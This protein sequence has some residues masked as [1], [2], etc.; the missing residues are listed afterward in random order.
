MALNHARV[1]HALQKAVNAARDEFI[2]A[3]LAAFGTSP[4]TL[5]LLESRNAAS[6]PGDVALA[7]KIYI[8]A[9]RQGCDLE[10]ALAEIRALPEI[11][12]KKIRFILAHDFERALAFD[13]KTTDSAA[14]AFADL[15][16]NYEFFL[17]LTG[18][19]EKAETWSD[20]PADLRACE[21]MGQLY[22]GI[23]RKNADAR[24]NVHLLNV[25]L[26]RLLFCFFAE[27]T[28]IFPEERQMTH[29]LA[30]HTQTDGSDVARFFDDLFAVLDLPPDARE[31]AKYPPWI[32]A[33]PYV[34]GSLF[35]EKCPIPVFDYRMR[36]LLLQCGNMKW[37]EISPAIF[38]SMFQ[39]VM[40]PKKR[41]GLGAHYTSEKNILKLIRPLFLDDLEVAFEKIL[42]RK[43]G[44]AAALKDY[45]RNLASLGFL[46]P[47]CGC[48]NFLII[49]FR[50]IRE[51]ELR[52]LLALAQC[53]GA[54]NSTQ[55]GLEM[56]W[57]DVG[58]LSAISIDQ[59]H[60]IE[61]EEFPAQIARVSLWL[62][63]HVMNM[64][65]GRAFGRVVSS[66]PLKTS[67]RIV[68]GD[69]LDLEWREVAEPARTSYILG[70]P[71]FGGSSGLD[72][73]RKGQMRAI[74]GNR[75]GKLDYVAAWYEKAAAFMRHNP[76]IQAAFVST[77][78]ICQGE[79]VAPLWQELF[80]RGIRI[81][82]AHQTFQWSNEARDNAA[83]YCVIIGFSYCEKERKILFAYDNPRS[84]AAWHYCRHINPYLAPA[85]LVIVT[86]AKKALSAPIPMVYGNKPTDGGNLI[87]EARDID[88]FLRK[89]PQGT[90]FVK[91][92]IGSE[93]FLH[94]KPRYCL[95]LV[96]A[97][98]E[99]LELPEIAKRIE[100]CRQMRLA[101]VDAGCRRLAERAHLFRDL[102]NPPSSLAIPG[103]S[104]ERREYIPIGF[105]DDST[106]AS[107]LVHI[108]PNAGLYEFGIV[109]SAMHMA[110][111][112]IVCGRLKSD[113]RYSRDLCYN[114]FPWPRVGE[115]Q[116]ERVCG[117]A[118]HVLE[119]REKYPQFTLAQLYD[120]EKMPADLR[121]AHAALD[122][123]V[124]ALY[125]KKPFADDADR[126]RLL[127]AL[128]KKLI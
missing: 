18:L 91:K 36:Y 87:I 89:E 123:A 95:W 90:P 81:N 92:L 83:V 121:A 59:F 19:Y 62:M 15:P 24:D 79:Q 44:R 65:L 104:S 110:W 61:I 78:S 1:V 28:G 75:G 34:N 100:G 23:L 32:A 55:A 3:F 74:L 96:D 2:P 53:A 128:Y 54:E 72:K 26:T 58:R 13:G 10:A 9:A 98:P 107:N 67:A 60:G 46:D 68:G 93:E 39:A 20:H 40:D 99:I 70:N 94:K 11:S 117:L 71:P 102:C 6:R 7:G 80:D 8:H 76:Q 17:P 35:A 112:R 105:I 63:E 33:F 101:S 73:K 119:L 113:Y 56:F 124:D 111:M 38:G 82:F 37:S 84:E 43:S 116:R 126:Q 16:K 120:P 47:A 114:T 51:L 108:V 57:E 86:A 103:V 127:F 64:K 42:A 31:R 25:F 22:D 45:L 29:A 85:P 49:A 125:R 14:F 5:R 27:D 4:A 52:A 30:T 106:I 48:G 109:S 69:A 50:E 115:G 12:S 88:A 77:N 21:K 122:A 118:G 41:R 66:I 97:P